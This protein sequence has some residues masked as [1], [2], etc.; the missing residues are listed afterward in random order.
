MDAKEPVTESYE[1]APE[2]FADFEKFSCG[3]ADM[4]LSS[5][6]EFLGAD[7]QNYVYEQKM[8][9]AFAQSVGAKQ[10]SPIILAYTAFICGLGKGIEL[11]EHIKSA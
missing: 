4:F 5:L 7:K 1:S 9:N 10:N 11:A 8:I 2:P 3:I 6:E